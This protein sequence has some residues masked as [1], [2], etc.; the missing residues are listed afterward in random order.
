MKP[1]FFSSICN[2]MDAPNVVSFGENQ[3]KINSISANDNVHR[4]NCIIFA[5][6]PSLF[7]GKVFRICF[8]LC[9]MWLFNVFHRCC[10]AYCCVFYHK[11]VIY[12]FSWILSRVWES[13]THSKCYWILL[14]PVWFPLFYHALCYASE[15][16]NE[17]TW[18]SFS[19][20]FI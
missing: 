15:M 16:Q 4:V 9:S 3:Q 18:L 6:F 19:K 2:R 17:R 5:R 13:A 11:M 7:L 1:H 8:I 10:H 20:I 14:W 12:L